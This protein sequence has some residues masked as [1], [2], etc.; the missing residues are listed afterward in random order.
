M[1]AIGDNS[2]AAL[3][4]S[5]RAEWEETERIKREGYAAAKN[6]ARETKKAVLERQVTLIGPKLNE[7][8]KGRS[9]EEFGK[10]VSTNLPFL[11][12]TKSN[13]RL[14]MMWAAEFP[15]QYQEMREKHPKCLSIRMLH[16][17]WKNQEKEKEKPTKP[18]KPTT[19]PKPEPTTGEPDD[20]GD[21]DP[22]IDPE[23]GGD[24]G[25]SKPPVQLGNPATLNGQ[26][27]Q[28]PAL[29]IIMTRSFRGR[30]QE[31]IDRMLGHV[32]ESEETA[33][34]TV[35]ALIEMRSLINRAIDAAEEQFNTTY[36][37]KEQMI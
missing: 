1:A 21:D 26:A 8:R 23:V 6:I 12:K 19:D 14:A 34:L 29:A 17:H 11:V 24:T 4:D 37:T 3:I 15:E 7:L 20:D 9:N 2:K 31:F 28:I 27:Q 13:V 25:G 10:L 30:D 35:P 36:P 16:Q 5:L 18:K 32:F 33:R 22:L